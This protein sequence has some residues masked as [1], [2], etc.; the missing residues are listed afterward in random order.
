MKAEWR[1]TLLQAI[2][3]LNRMEEWRVFE[4]R[5]SGENETGIR[6]LVLFFPGM[7]FRPSIPPSSTMGRNFR[8][9]V[10]GVG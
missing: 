6:T 2:D 8:E 5:E 9:S 4:K 1:M 7:R 3:F 10:P